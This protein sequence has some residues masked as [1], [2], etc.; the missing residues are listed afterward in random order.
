MKTYFKSSYDKDVSFGIRYEPQIFKK[1]FPN[2]VVLVAYIPTENPGVPLNLAE[3]EFSGVLDDD[4]I[5]PAAPQSL[6]RGVSVQ[7]APAFRM[8]A[9]TRITRS[10]SLEEHD[11]VERESAVKRGTLQRHSKVGDIHVFVLSYSVDQDIQE[12]FSPVSVKMKFTIGA[13]SV[14]ASFP[15]TTGNHV[16]LGAIVKS[17]ISQMAPPLAAY[18]AFLSGI[19]ALAT[20]KSNAIPVNHDVIIWLHGASLSFVREFSSS[21]GSESIG[22]TDVLSVLSDAYSQ[23]S[24]DPWII[25]VAIGHVVGTITI[26]GPLKRHKFLNIWKVPQVRFHVI[27]VMFFCIQYDDD[28]TNIN[29]CICVYL[30]IYLCLKE[31]IC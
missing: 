20:G 8:K 9:A 11:E 17:R 31:N 12:A 19:Q 2:A 26:T 1:S 10:N 22:L 30:C 23:E 28:D 16:V 3:I 14:A 29:V 27:K 24:L 7:S 5:I 15:M 13:D 21:F 6:R 25:L 18:E 4:L